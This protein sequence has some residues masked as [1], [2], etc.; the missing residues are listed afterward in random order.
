MAEEIYKIVVIDNEHLDRFIIDRCLDLYGIKCEVREF[1]NALKAVNYFR[2]ID[3]KKTGAPDMVITDMKIDGADGYDVIKSIRENPAT[4]HIPV[5]AMTSYPATQ[6]EEKALSLGADLFFI[7]PP[8]I[9]IM[10]KI[11]A[12]MAHK[13]NQSL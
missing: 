9:A 12:L 7:K 13:N 6:M 3:S 4:A 8:S 11:A 5:V 2:S 1:D 10:D